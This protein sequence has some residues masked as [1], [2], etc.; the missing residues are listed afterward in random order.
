[1]QDNT[2]LRLELSFRALISMDNL[3]AYHGALW[4]ALFRNLLAPYMPAETSLAETGIMPVC[5]QCKVS[6]SQGEP[7]H[8]EMLV[9]APW[10]RPVL[11]MLWDF[12]RLESR[13]QFSPGWSLALRE[14]RCGVTERIVA[15]FNGNDSLANFDSLEPL[16]PCLLAD[17][18]EALHAMKAFTVIFDTPLRLKRPAGA[19]AGGHRY[20]DRTFFLRTHSSAAVSRLAENIRMYGPKARKTDTCTSQITSGSLQWIDMPYGRDFPKTIGGVSGYVRATGGLDPDAAMRLAWGQYTGAGKNGAFGF[21]FY[22]IPEL[23]PILGLAGPQARGL[24]RFGNC[25][26]ATVRE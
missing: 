15:R 14:V 18:A 22:H 20:C 24:R 4:S 17:A 7:V 16:D 3:P 1:M 12:N 2:L 8:L 11:E 21:G 26:P 6:L 10:V 23:N 5:R 9:P 19:K 25:V 13:G